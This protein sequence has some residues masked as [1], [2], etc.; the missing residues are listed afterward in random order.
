VA[1]IPLV[2]ESPR[3]LVSQGHFNR[4]IHYRLGHRQKRGKKAKKKGENSA[5]ICMSFFVC[6]EVWFAFFGKYITNSKEF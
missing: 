3:W 6:L 5:K 2:P 4:W 1:A